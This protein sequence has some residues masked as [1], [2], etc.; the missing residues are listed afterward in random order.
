[1]RKL[2]LLQVYFETHPAL[3]F[4]F[5]LS[6]LLFACAGILLISHKVFSQGF[7][8]ALASSAE[9]MNHRPVLVLHFPLLYLHAADKACGFRI[10]II[11]QLHHAMKHPRTEI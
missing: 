7:V 10:W 2:T 8:G 6:F 9:H 1:M 5:G 3:C 11:P 4:A